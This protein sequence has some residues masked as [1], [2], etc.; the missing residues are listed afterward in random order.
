[1]NELLKYS[2]NLE[3]D[4]VNS[5]PAYQSKMDLALS[6]LVTGDYQKSKQ[7]FDSAIEIDSTFPSAWLGKAFAEIA[8]V[9]DDNFNSIVIDEYLSRAIRSTD[10]ILKYKVAIAGCLAY[11]HATI[12]RKNVLIVEEALKAK[13]EAEKAK[14]RAITTAVVGTFFVG[15]DKGTM[16]NIVGGT[17]IAGGTAK[18]MQSHLHAKE[19]EVLGNSLYSAA[20]AQTY[21]S[22]PILYL[23]STLT[24]QIDDIDL[25][26]N[27]TVITDSWKESVI[28]LYNKQKEQL[29]N[30]LKKFSVGEASNVQQLLDNPNSIQEIG[31]FSAFM[32]IIG[33]AEHKIFN[34]LSTLFKQTLPK[35]FDNPES[36]TALENAKK[37]QK[38]AAVLGTIIL[39]IGFGSIY[40]DYVQQQDNAWLPWVIDIAG[41]ALGV[42]L[43]LAARTKEMKEFEKIYATAIN[44]INTTSIS[45]TD[46]NL[47][48]IEK[49][50]STSNSN[51]FL[52]SK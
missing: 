47:N 1:M 34:L 32:K 10:N 5:N 18:A 51:N 19:L 7:M 17:L 49:Q 28:Y 36:K 50:N 37:K 29:V 21:L 27:F 35:Y 42:F 52:D 46:F 24:N 33:L 43:S 4:F 45:I 26:N 25:K 9:D 15:K 6:C 41:I 39:L 23:C 44:E 48:L 22:T 16:S 11:R 3:V 14:S 12:I 31:E 40:S 13:K 30:K 38:R 20:L 8:L 2:K